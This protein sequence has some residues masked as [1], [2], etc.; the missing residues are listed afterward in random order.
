V[1]EGERDDER[2]QGEPD[3]A[4]QDR[5]AGK[6]APRRRTRD[7]L[8]DPFKAQRDIARMVD[9]V[10]ENPVLK[11]MR[12]QRKMMRWLFEDVTRNP[13]L[14]QHRQRQEMM[15]KMVD[16]LTRNPALDML[17][18]QRRQREM[19]L[20]SLT[21]QN[22]VI[23]AFN[24]GYAVRLLD[25]AR[26]AAQ[27]VVSQL[28]DLQA[29]QD[30]VESQQLLVDEAAQAE[31]EG[32]EFD[33]SA[34]GGP[35]LNQNALQTY[36][37][38][39]ALILSLVQFLTDRGV[40]ADE[41]RAITEQQTHETQKL[42]EKQTQEY[43]EAIDRETDE[44]KKAIESVQRPELHITVEPGGKLIVKEGALPPVDDA[45]AHEEPADDSTK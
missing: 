16:D 13:V 44:L 32:R 4:G 34:H 38:V 33:L 9:P 8:S 29:I 7:P 45:A 30:W 37:A 14:E 35:K 21:P 6:P 43:I 41:Q 28:Q 22:I 12:E 36:I 23:D 3:D 18:Q 15:R 27:G 20:K 11:Q 10:R 26:K 1:A 42:I 25:D 2:E 24:Q 5:D 19:L 39:L 40:T 17:E 31:E